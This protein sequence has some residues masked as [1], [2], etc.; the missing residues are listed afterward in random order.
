M[1]SRVN[2][3]SQPNNL[4]AVPDQVPSND[5]GD[6][7]NGDLYAS[8][9]ARTAGLNKNAPQPWRRSG[10]ND[11][12]KHQR[13]ALF[14]PSRSTS[15]HSLF[16]AFRCSNSN[17]TNIQCLQRKMDGEV[18]VTVKTLAVKEIFTSKFNYY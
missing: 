17:L 15:A 8:R 4:N 5:G 16:E 10:A 1:N 13:T 2:S 11:T 3:P 6:V 18:V 14:T 12:P 9:A 7:V